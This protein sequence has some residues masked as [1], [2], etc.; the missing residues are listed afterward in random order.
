MDRRF[1]IGLLAL[2]PALLLTPSPAAGQCEPEL[3]E[4][5]TTDDLHDQF[6]SAVAIDRDLMVIGASY[7]HQAAPYAGALYVY[8]ATG[9]SW[10]L[11]QKITASIAKKNDLLGSAVAA[12]GDLI[13]AGAPGDDGFR[14]AVYV[15]QLQMG[16][17][18][19]VAKLVAPDLEEKSQFGDS[20]A[21]SVTDAGPVLAGGAHAWWPNVEG[22]GAVH[23]Y[24]RTA[25]VWE[26]EAELA[27]A[28]GEP[29]RGFGLSV[30]L[31]GNQV[32]VGSPLSP[33]AVYVFSHSG[34]DWIENCILVPLDPFQGQF[35]GADVDVDG[36]TAVVGTWA[37]GEFEPLP[38]AAYVFGAA[39][40]EWSQIAKLTPSD[41][42]D[43]EF[44]IKVALE[45]DTA[46]VGA[47]QAESAY[48]Y[49]RT[50]NGWIEQAQ[51]ALTGLVNI[52]DVDLQG[53]RLA[54]G[55]RAETVVLYQLCELP[56]Y[57]DLDNSGDLTLFDFLT[58]INVFNAED[59]AADCD[60]NGSLDLFDFLCF[61][62]AFNTGC[63]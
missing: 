9:D 46:V 14:G 42:M 43:E 2:A 1:L 54:V 37:Y 48:V 4:T 52:W 5:F 10:V 61:V 23:V 21:L 11:Q 41:G 53:H 32:F 20:V 51:L 17:W 29:H 13:V 7:D 19:Q 57:A 3:V 56:C 60:V 58:F 30:D 55:D 26:W 28:D 16:V 44:G 33:S 8:R 49:A 47:L 22:F 62:N 24:R 63:E 35:F 6:G 15:F 59:E 25:E 31:D 34:G 39:G 45:G 18:T 36:K 38:G 40:G 27:P 50:P 12:S